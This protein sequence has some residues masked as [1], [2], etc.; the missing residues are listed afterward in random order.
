M[1]SDT[2]EQPGTAS[3]F[4]FP[5]YI[6]APYVPTPED[7]I[8]RMLRLAE[9]NGRDFVYDLGCGDGRIIIS[10]ALK[11][12]ARGLGVDIEPYWISESE[13]AAKNAGVEELVEFKL[14]DALTLELSPATV[15]MLYLV[16][17]SISKILPIIKNQ[18]KAGT[19]IVS[20]SFG[21][22]D[23]QPLKTESFTDESGAERTLYLWI[24]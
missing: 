10:A 24:K 2:N 15:V 11:C 1:S 16:P 12:G 20:H 7:V 9:V 13:K 8:E 3:G 6:L 22:E 19:R 21:G 23:W 5:K 4:V 14:Q 18:V 17:W